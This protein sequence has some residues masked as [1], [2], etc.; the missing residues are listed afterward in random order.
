MITPTVIGP[1]T[2]L[3]PEIAAPG[4]AL[5]K[6]LA[7]SSPR[8]LSIRTRASAAFTAISAT[9]T[10]SSYSAGSILTNVSFAS[11]EPPLPSFG[12][13]QATRPATS[14]LSLALSDRLT[15]PVSSTA[16][17][18]CP[19]GVGSMTLTTGLVSS[20]ES[21][22]TV[23][24][25][26]RSGARAKYRATAMTARIRDNLNEAEPSGLAGPVFGVV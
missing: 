1:T 12:E 25:S 16:V 24:R 15:E 7:A 18:A 26:T 14:D 9:F 8:V 22:E 20:A 23:S 11:I 3:A 13:T 10:R 4:F 6:A 19:V 5:A 17:S 2:A 21:V